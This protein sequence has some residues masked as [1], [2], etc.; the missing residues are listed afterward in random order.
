MMPWPPP[1]SESPFRIPKTEALRRPDPRPRCL[2]PA[3]ERKELLSLLL[4]EVLVDVTEDRII[5]VT[6]K[7][8]FVALFQQVPGLKERDGCFH[9][10]SNGDL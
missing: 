4:E 3:M 2:P 5:C 10:S 6:P 1:Q 7:A 9:L 8:S